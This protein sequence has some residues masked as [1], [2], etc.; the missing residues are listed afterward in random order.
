MLSVLHGTSQ[1]QVWFFQDAQKAILGAIF[2][3]VL[4]PHVVSIQMTFSNRNDWVP[5]SQSVSLQAS[6]ITQY[7]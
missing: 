5:K 1:I 2:Y 6:Y 7:Q 4:F 3:P